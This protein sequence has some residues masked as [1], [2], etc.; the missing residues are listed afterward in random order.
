M[1]YQNDLMSL[2]DVVSPAYAAGQGMQQEDLEN[3]SKQLANERYAGQNPAEIARP[4]LQ[5]MFT[6]A[7]TGAEQGVA[8]QQQAKGTLDQSLLPG[9]IKTGQAENETK[10]GAQKLQQFGQMGQIANQAAGLMDNI[11]EAARPAAMQQL[12]Q[13]YG[14][15]PQ[16]LGPLA[17]GDPDMLRNFGQKLIQSSADYQ[18]KLMQEQIHGQTAENVANISGS[19]RVA[20]AEASANARVQAANI[21]AQ[22]R[23]QQQTAEQAAVAAAKRG[24]TASANA[25]SQLAMNLKQAQAGIT[26]QLVMG[27]NIPTPNFPTQGNT[28]GGQQQQPPKINPTTPAAQQ[29]AKSIWPNDDPSKYEYQYG[30]DGV[31]TARRLIQGK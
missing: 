9:Q 30:P 20:G 17:N 27:Q 7:Q 12:A 29:L 25:Y 22:M 2:A 11:P 31:P 5:N 3:Q 4:G 21:T 13:K 18:T 24:D 23:Q 8:A 28:G 10:Y 6:Q 14:I 26:S 19:A 15:D 16:A 1:P